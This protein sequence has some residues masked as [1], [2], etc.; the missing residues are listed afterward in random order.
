[1]NPLSRRAPMLLRGFL[2]G[3]VFAGCG[4]GGT[5]AAPSMAPSAASQSSG[6]GGPGTGA[7]QAT[8]SPGPAGTPIVGGPAVTLV[9]DEQGPH[10]A[11]LE[12]A[13]VHPAVGT[14][15]LVGELAVAHEL[16]LAAFLHLE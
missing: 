13:V 7:N 14:D 15:D 11:L 16:E 4:P 6:S 9:L 1:M 2:A 10:A 3:A 12:V 5:P 8:G